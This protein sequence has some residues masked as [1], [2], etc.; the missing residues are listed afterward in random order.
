MTTDELIAALG[1]LIERY[2]KAETEHDKLKAQTDWYAQELRRRGSP[3]QMAL[4]SFST[5][6]ISEVLADVRADLERTYEAWGSVGG[7]MR[8]LGG[9]T[10]RAK[11]RVLKDPSSAGPHESQKVLGG[12]IPE[13]WE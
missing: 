8:R 3:G 13:D 9:L 7:E 2:A 5:D 10:P 12:V 11:L 6:R 1:P 4:A